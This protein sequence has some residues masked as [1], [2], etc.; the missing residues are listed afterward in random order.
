MKD[1]VY[2]EDFEGWIPL[3]PI[4]NNKFLIIESPDGTQEACIHLADNEVVG[5]KDKATGADLYDGNKVLAE[6]L[7]L[8]WLYKAWKVMERNG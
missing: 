6:K 2:P 5:I 3:Y 4:N 1:P 7:G 8:N